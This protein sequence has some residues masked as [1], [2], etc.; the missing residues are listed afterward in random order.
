MTTILTYDTSAF[1]AVNGLAGKHPL[2][3]AFG[4]F[5]AHWLIVAM[6]VTVALR[7]LF[8]VG[9]RNGDVAMLFDAG[10]RGGIAGVLAFG[11]SILA[12][13][14]LFRARPYVALTGVARLMNDPVTVHSFP[15]SHSSAAFAL[16][17]AVFS[18]D[19]AFGGALLG[20]AALVGFGRVFVGVHY[21]GDIIGGAL[22]GW[23]GAWALGKAAFVGTV[24]AFVRR[25]FIGRFL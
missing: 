2:L 15:S 8:L 6:F 11:A 25:A 23:V 7:A 5:C 3:D 22:L 4:I 9:Q 20:A 19:R 14:Y 24:V 10:L 1:R 12:S 16:A 13:P 17:F 21:P 18:V